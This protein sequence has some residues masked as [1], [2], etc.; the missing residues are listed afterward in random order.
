M[1]SQTKIRKGD[2]VCADHQ[3][4]GAKDLLAWLKINPS[5]PHNHLAFAARDLAAAKRR[6]P[7]P[8]S[9]C[10]QRAQA[11]R[12]GKLTYLE[13]VTDLLGA[14]GRPL[15]VTEI[16]ENMV[17]PPSRSVYGRM[18]RGVMDDVIKALKRG[19]ARS[20]IRKI[21]NPRAKTLYKDHHY[22]LTS[23]D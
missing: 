21:T 10:S 18:P 16:L 7:P 1:T 3:C 12:K 4:Y 22:T 23:H 8:R 15:N 2:G 19:I 9:G 13:S 17:V 20:E 5:L 6:R 11:R 14:A